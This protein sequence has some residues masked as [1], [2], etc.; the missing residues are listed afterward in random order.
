MVNPFVTKKINYSISDLAKQTKN[1]CFS[2]TSNLLFS[3]ERYCIGKTLVWALF[4]R[5][6]FRNFK[7]CYFY[8]LNL[9]EFEFATLVTPTWSEHAAFQSNT[10]H[11]LLTEWHPFTFDKKK[12]KI[13]FLLIFLSVLQNNKSNLWERHPPGECTAGPELYCRGQTQLTCSPGSWDL[14][15]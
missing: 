4:N 11:K 1:Y 14:N 15:R 12:K 6:H 8:S 13:G 7:F 3:I 5:A 9:V 2:W 10:Q